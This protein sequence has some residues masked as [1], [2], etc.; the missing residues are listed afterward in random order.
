[1]RYFSTNRQVPAATFAH[2]VIEG[3]AADRGLFMPETI[4]CLPDS[5]F[6]RLPLLSLPEIGFEIARHFV[7]HEIDAAQL[8]R[9]CEESLNFDIPLIELDAHTHVLELFHGPTLAFKDVGARFMSR[10]MAHLLRDEKKKVHVL[11]ATSG[12]TGSAV[13]QGFYQVPGIEVVIIY[14]AGKVSAVQQAQFCTL[15]ENITVLEINGTFDDCQRLVKNAFSDVSLR[16]L[17][18]LTSANSINFARLLPQSFYYFYA[19][20]QFQKKYQMPFVFSVPSGNYGNLTAGLLAWRM[21][22]PVRRFI[23]AA[24]ANDTVPDYL[25]SAYYQAKPSVQTLSSAMDV[26]DP[27]N[28][29]RMRHLFGD[30][31]IE[32]KEQIAGYSF[33]DADTRKSMAEIHQKYNYL[34]DPHGAVGY[35][36][37][38]N[39]QKKEENLPGVILATAH[40]VKFAEAVSQ[41][42]SQQPDV[43][44]SL[45]ILLGK[46]QKSIP[47]ANDYAAL[48]DFLIAKNR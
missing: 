32:M 30:S 1:M 2:A 31:W 29:A 22:L 23:A 8:R 16:G 38:R 47:L 15:G 14:P 21:G 3:L 7:G 43:P 25:Q 36:A 27:S 42:T 19:Y 45:G 20:Q 12:D 26:G 34:M 33:S 24:N 35:W 48:K 17:L 13:A 6:N 44:H 37:L 5:F 39:Y 11:V 9:I 40:P 4:P 10:V 41:A 28:F 18:Y 46:E